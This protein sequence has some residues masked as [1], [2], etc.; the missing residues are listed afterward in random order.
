MDGHSVAC[1]GTVLTGR[2]M[3]DSVWHAMCNACAGSVRIAPA[4]QRSRTSP[5][6]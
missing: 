4:W 3:I 1:G 2:M 6:H 5:V